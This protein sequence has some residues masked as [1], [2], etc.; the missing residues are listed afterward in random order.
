M[1]ATD[2]IDYYNYGAYFQAAY[3]FLPK[4]QGYV[5][6][7]YVSPG[8]QV[9]DLESYRAPGI[10]VNFF[11]IKNIRWR[12]TAEVNYL[13]SAFNKTIVEP[14]PELGWVETDE[15]GQTSFRVQLQ[16]GF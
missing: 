2:I 7:D 5:R 16:L 6:Y 10:G 3:F 9:G 4:W 11:P 1:S 14:V 12:V 13:F 15:K 8:D